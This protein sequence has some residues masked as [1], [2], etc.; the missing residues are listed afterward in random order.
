MLMYFKKIRETFVALKD[1][2]ILYSI[3]LFS[4]YLQILMWTD[5]MKKTSFTMK[6]GNYYFKVIPFSLTNAPATF[7]QEMNCISFDLINDCI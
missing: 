1:A 5:D 2:K 6:F 3:N 4:G 7:Q